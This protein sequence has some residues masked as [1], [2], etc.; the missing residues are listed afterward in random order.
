MNVDA[1]DVSAITRS[2]NLSFPS[3]LPYIRGF[4]SAGG[5]VRGQ[6]C[7]HR[8]FYGA[9]G[10]RILATDH[11]G[12]PIHECE[13]II[14]VD[15]TAKLARAR[16]RLDWGT[17][18]GIKPEGIVN[19]ITLDL[20]TKPG[21]EQLRTEDL[22]HMAAQALQVPYEEI[23]FFYGEDDLVIGARGQATIGHKKDALYIL[24]DGT[25]ER[26]RFM[27]CMG[28]M[29]WE[30]I[31]FLPVVE[32]F[33][34][35]L[36]GTGSAVFE[37]I[38]GL[39]DDQ[40][41]GIHRPLR[42]RGI[43]TYPSEAA[44]RLF[45]AFFTPQSPIGSDP[46]SVFMDAPRSHLV[47]W[48]PAPDPPRRHFDTARRLCITVK[49][50]TIQKATLADDPTGLSFVLAHP[51]GVAPGERT[52]EVQKGMLVLNDRDTRT[53]LPLSPVWGTI[54][55]S[56]PPRPA[57]APIGWRAFFGES[58]PK[59]SP[60]QAFSAVLLYPD[61]DTEIEEAAT[62]PF[63]A[64]YLQDTIEE[65]PELAAHLARS[66]RVLIH[67]FDAALMSCI[68]LDRAR[69]Y[70]ILYHRPEF[71]Q[72]HAQSLWNL[73]ART[74]RL[75]WAKRIRLLPADRSRQEAYQQQYD[76]LYEWVPFSQFKH[77]V[78]LEET[79]RAVANALTPAG[80]AFVVG[81]P[82]MGELLQAHRVRL[83]R[84][85]AVETLPTFRMHQAILPQARLKPDLTL[86]QI[87]KG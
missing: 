51:Q 73:M 57:L 76:V 15:G 64:D 68:H 41:T 31:D 25:F 50:N 45:S 63:V 38:R 40:N 3:N 10:R 6:A 18:V 75:D 11:E 28:A 87:M 60:A 55:D 21:W 33:Q 32:L 29:H 44:F 23:R 69:D 7:G 36:P 56:L 85:E 62:Q 49:G 35:L 71:A 12:N 46:F 78:D 19:T 72:K 61:D 80:V 39:Y 42:Y 65:S 20:S 9:H 58:L 53:E 47:T 48:L 70:A 67:N 54:R 17:W 27:A 77:L 43:P 84:V 13:W 30:Q 79:A 59:V 83:A 24:D 86:F 1:A 2:G 22:R 26:S 37:L 66:S 16:V 8:V 4:A 52:V 81:P 14:A 74:Q 34:S 82:T 5:E